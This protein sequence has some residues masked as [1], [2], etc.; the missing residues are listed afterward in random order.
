MISDP[1][2]P[3]L[4]LV[5][6]LRFTVVLS[7][8]ATGSLNA[9]TQIGIPGKF[10]VTPIGAASYTIP[11]EVPP[12]VGGMEPKLA[13]VYNSRAGNGILGMGWSITGLPTITRCP[14]TTP[15]DG[16]KGAVAYGE[17]DRFCLDGQRLV[18][19]S[20]VYGAAGSTYATEIDT[21]ARV[22]AYGVA[23]VGPQY[24]IVNTRDGQKAEFGSTKDSR[25]VVAN[26]GDNG[27]VR[28]WSM[29]R[30][31]DK[32]GNAQVIKYGLPP[33]ISTST[34]EYNA[35]P[36]R[37][38][39]TSNSSK[40]LAPTNSVEFNYSVR[41][42][43][44]RAYQAG[45]PSNVSVRLSSLV[46]TAG[47]GG[48][49]TGG[50]S[51]EVVAIYKP[52]YSQLDD[53]K[54]SVM[55]SLSKCAPDGLCA[56]AAQFG[57]STSSARVMQGL[58]PRVMPVPQAESSVAKGVWQSLDI[59]GDGKTDLVHLIEGGGAY[60]SWLSNGDG[61][62]T[63]REYTTTRDSAANA[64]L[65]RV[66]DVNGDGRADLIH[67]T[68]APGA[69]KVWISQ[70]DGEFVVS[71]FNTPD[72]LSLKVG[73]WLPIDLNGDGLGDLVHLLPSMNP[74]EP[75]WIWLSN[76]DG[77]FSIKWANGTGGTVWEWPE[78][79]NNYI[80]DK[81]LHNA[82]FGSRFQVF[83][84]NGDG[85]ADIIQLVTDIAGYSSPPRAQRRMVVRLSKGNGTFTVLSTRL[86]EYTT[87]DNAGWID[88]MVPID[89]NGD[90]LMDFMR[91]ANK[92]HFWDG[93]FM[94]KQAELLVSLGDGTFAGVPAPAA[95]G[96]LHEGIWFPVD[97]NGDGLD[98]LVRAPPNLSEGWYQVLRSNGDHTFAVDVISQ[99]VDTCSANCT[100]VLPGDFLGAGAPGFV[101]VDEYGVRSAWLVSKPIG[102][103]LTSVSNGLNDV[104][105]WDL[106]A[107]PAMG[108]SYVRDLPSTSHVWTQTPAVPVVSAVRSRVTSWSIGSARSDL[109]RSTSYSYG[110]A[111]V[112]RNGRG[113][114]GFR[115]LQASDLDTGLSSRTYF[116]QTF[117]ATGRAEIEGTGA[118]GAWNNLT[119]RTTN[120]ECT[121]LDGGNSCPTSPGRRYFVYPSRI[122]SQQWD[123]D[124]TPMPRTQVVN[125]SPDNFGN[126]RRT[127]TTTLHPD[128][129]PSGYS[130]TVDNEYYNAD[131][132]W[133]IGR[134]TKSTVTSTA[135]DVGASVVPG[136]GNLPA[137]PNPQ[138]PPRVLA[139]LS[140]IFQLLLSDD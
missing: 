25:V 137:A 37:I 110:S 58:L 66:L 96:K 139:T 95:E 121:L 136:S 119:L 132:T 67:F 44:L 65:W 16:V 138:L 56:A 54:R 113:F 28:V 31:E 81:N 45:K 47:S 7:S 43:T 32:F 15:Q 70:G 85:L 72:D 53:L 36:L 4:D 79:P 130:K 97:V 83:D 59:N 60:R 99:T 109:E 93:S 62:F 21:F 38:D 122:E 101:R 120:Y 90:G 73:K 40:G 134:L 61:S 86:G 135:P 1:Q 114:L 48:N 8:L 105:S 55:S 124:G 9:A 92:Q 126:I 88:T 22:T 69:A 13:F 29:N 82:F 108:A 94:G 12:G 118:G 17:Q 42:Y 33:A 20:G 11:I 115:W 18:L 10:E 30:V 57:P 89:A 87:P 129:S 125:S 51:A 14:R 116:N 24:F 103:L 34:T 39:Y 111:R 102:G 6:F 100:E 107:L 41:P 77:T 27:V 35:Y 131:S 80:R 76:G 127:V 2:R 63:I 123:L 50:A 140:T 19:T 49:G 91:L 74:D 133:I 5:R 112:E 117:P 46:T 75:M 84:A 23:G 98:D 128:G 104:T 52:E 71:D 64:D 78:G 68:A 26:G 3:L 106:T